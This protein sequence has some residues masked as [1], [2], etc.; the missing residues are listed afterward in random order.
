MRDSLYL[1]WRYLRHH[2]AKTTLLVLSLAVFVG[3]PLVMRAMSAVIQ[4]SLMSRAEGTPLVLGKK[5]S[6]LDLVIEALYFEPKGVDPLSAADADAID[7]TGLAA[8]IPIRTGLMAMQHPMVGTSLEYF[9]LRG[10]HIA[11][12]RALATLGECVLGADAAEDSG[13][14]G[15]EAGDRRQ[16]LRTLPV[17][18]HLA[19]W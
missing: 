17:R 10:L 6:S 19:Q 3:L 15:D 1:A 9:A 16:S 4:Q 18:F 2:R 8:A 11:E 14:F 7:D 13:A 12:G 5:G